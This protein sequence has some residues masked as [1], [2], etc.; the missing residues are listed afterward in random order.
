MCR[1]GDTRALDLAAESADVVP[2]LGPLYH[3][4][5][6]QPSSRPSAGAVR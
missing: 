6:A 2:L 3:L 1:T 4:T 5:E